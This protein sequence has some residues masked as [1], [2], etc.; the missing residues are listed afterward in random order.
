[1]QFI[2]NLFRLIRDFPL[3]DFSVYMD[4]VKH[5]LTDNPY[6]LK[7]FDYYN[8]PPAA[9]LFFY[10]F[11]LSPIDT[12]ETIFTIISLS[13]LFLSLFLLYKITHSKFSPYWLVPITYLL[14]RFAPTRLTLTLG[15]INLVVL[16]LILLAFYWRKSWLGGISLGLAFIL[17][18]TPAFLLL[19][20]ILKKQWRVII[21]F[22]YTVI[23]LHFLA[24]LVF[25]WDLTFYYYT[26]VLPRLLSQTGFYT[27]QR[28][29]M[30]QSLTAFL[31]R[32]G[33]FDTYHAIVKLILVL[34]LVW[35]T[36]RKKLD[37]ATYSLFLIIMTVFIPT[38]AWQHHYVFL[39]PAIFILSLRH[40]ALGISAYVLLTFTI[41]PSFPGYPNP[42]I[43]SH[44]FL[45]SLL[46]LFLGSRYYP[47]H[48]SIRGV[49]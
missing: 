3:N 25:G 48:K 30:N 33:I 44:L 37:F 13:S 24:I 46:V 5:T 41:G 27:M 26:Q 31:G 34:P 38:F 21:G 42:L 9:T 28:T 22:L 11:T 18:F 17:K 36:A 16:L 35:F 4:G 45:S 40:W 43:H 29:Y 32:L 20:F 7:F 49:P 8:Y 2:F 39:I 23:L 19:F 14:F 12:A 15:Q 10:P 1:M 6:T 47:N